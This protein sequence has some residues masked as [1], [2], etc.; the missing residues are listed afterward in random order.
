MRKDRSER[1]EG[2]GEGKKSGKEKTL[3]AGETVWDN[4]CGRDKET[5]GEGERE[6]MKEKKTLRDSAAVCV[7]MWEK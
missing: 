5:E 4:L 1:E 2:M 3:R 6:R 7:F